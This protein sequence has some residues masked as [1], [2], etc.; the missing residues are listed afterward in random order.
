MKGSLTATTFTAPCS[1]LCTVRQSSS[2]IVGHK[3]KVGQGTYALRKTM[4]PIR[5]K[6]L[7]PTRVS[8][9]MIMSAA[10]IGVWFFFAE[11][12][13][14]GVRELWML[15]RI[16]GVF[17]RKENFWW[18]DPRLHRGATQTSEGLD[19][20]SASRRN[21]RPTVIHGGPRTATSARWQAMVK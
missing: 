7:M 5:P 3:G 14:W 17:R 20:I 13:G 18:G 6:P 12:G 21:H 9:M 1:T 11:N 4:R 15:E 16:G 2:E 10:G 8:D 19:S